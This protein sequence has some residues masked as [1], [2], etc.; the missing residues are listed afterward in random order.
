MM[1]IG[2]GFGPIESIDRVQGHGYYS[3]TSEELTYASYPEWLRDG[4]AEATATAL[5]WCKSHSM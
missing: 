2:R 4:P 1:F 3:A 5:T